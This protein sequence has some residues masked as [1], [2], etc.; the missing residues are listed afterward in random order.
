MAILEPTFFHVGGGKRGRGEEGKRMPTE[1]FFW[2]IKTIH[3]LILTLQGQNSGV[4][5]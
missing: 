4:A 1:F 5:C 2:E 3:I